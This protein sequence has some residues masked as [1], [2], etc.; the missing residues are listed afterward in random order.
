MNCIFDQCALINGLLLGLSTSAIVSI[1]TYVIVNRKN[2][3]VLKKKYGTPEGEY[4]GYGFERKYPDKPDSPL[5]KTLT[6][7]PISTATIKYIKDN[8]L[9][10]SLK[11]DE[12]VWTGEIIMESETSGSVAWRY[13]NLPL[14]NGKEQHWFGLKKVVVRNVEDEKNSYIY[15][16]GDTLEGF[17]KEILIRAK[18]YQRACLPQRWF[19]PKMGSK[20]K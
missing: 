11:H 6:N 16:I 20:L 5:K 7:E 12:K 4:L 19:C 1:I 17:G 18:T 14:D 9:S 15:L 13:I 10:I 8:I 2:K 3:K